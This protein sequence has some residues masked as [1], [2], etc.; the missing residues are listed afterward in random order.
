MKT[1]KILNIVI[2]VFI[3]FFVFNVGAVD[4]KYVYKVNNIGQTTS[5]IFFYGSDIVDVLVPEDVDEPGVKG[6]IYVDLDDGIKLS[7][8]DDE[9]IVAYK[10]FYHTRKKSGIWYFETVVK[11]N[12][13]VSL[14]LPNNIIV[15]QTTPRTS[16]VTKN[17]LKIV[18]WKNIQEQN[19]TVSYIFNN[20]NFNQ[21]NTS[22]EDRNYIGI[23]IGIIFALAI[24]IGS[25]HLFKRKI[26]KT[27][28]E[29]KEVP[30]NI[31]DGQMNI[32]RAA[33]PNEALI[34][35][36]IIRNNGH[37]KRNKLEK[38]TNLPKS[39]L[40]SSLKNLEKKN[41]VTIDRNFQVHYITLSEWF[42]EL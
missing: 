3:V 5:F 4:S 17:N 14:I 20:T 9:A 13:N 6:G 11:K 35:K 34:I 22:E 23:F 32:V 28:N 10:S 19:I 16:I 24:G 1:Y 33:N 38:S 8:N 39:S 37:I 12:S 7:M 25:Y 41:I 29:I 26:N 30:R 36:E 27:P 42:K 18:E 40:A 2:F 15:I 21:Q 31:T